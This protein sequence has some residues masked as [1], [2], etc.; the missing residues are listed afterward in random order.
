MCCE[1]ECVEVGDKVKGVF[2]VM[3]SYEVCILFNGMV[4]FMNLLLDML[5]LVE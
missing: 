3:M 2:F 1:K 5:F 4:G